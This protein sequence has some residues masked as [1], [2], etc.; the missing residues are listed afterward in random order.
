MFSLKLE[1]YI[2]SLQCT[3]KPDHIPKIAYNRRI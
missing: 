1:V 3:Y 2:L